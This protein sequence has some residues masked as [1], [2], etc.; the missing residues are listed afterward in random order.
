[1]DVVTVR[2]ALKHIHQG[3]E[4]G[5][6]NTG[7]ELTLPHREY[8]PA[9]GAQLGLLPDVVGDIAAK[10]VG[11]ERGP[12]LWHAAVCTTIVAVPEAAMDEEN[13]PELGQN[14]VWT[15]GQVLDMEAVS[16][17]LAMKMLTHNHLGLSVLAPDTGHYVTTGSWGE[18]I[19]HISVNTEWM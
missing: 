1:M 7:L 10:L 2:D 17:T 12:G 6:T 14:Q 11:P 8:A 4:C 9:V 15:T 5:L 3:G 18:G 13:S 19:R 16:K